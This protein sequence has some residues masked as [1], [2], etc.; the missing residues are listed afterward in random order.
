[1]KAFSSVS[2]RRGR[3]AIFKGVVRAWPEDQVF[4]PSVCNELFCCGDWGWIVQAGGQARIEGP[5]GRPAH[6][7]FE[8]M[9]VRVIGIPYL[10]AQDRQ[11][12]IHAARGSPLGFRATLPWVQGQAAS[13]VELGIER[14]L[15]VQAHLPGHDNRISVLYEVNRTACESLGQAVA[16]GHQPMLSHDRISS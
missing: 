8:Q 9:L 7:P 13:A 3:V 10:E 6:D 4:D 1:M 15:V 2:W 14:L 11:V 16:D 5:Q 12:M